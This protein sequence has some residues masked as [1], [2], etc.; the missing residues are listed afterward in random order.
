MND[1]YVGAD[2]VDDCDVNDDDMDAV[3]DVQ[4]DGVDY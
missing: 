1:T 4:Y 3:D 2:N